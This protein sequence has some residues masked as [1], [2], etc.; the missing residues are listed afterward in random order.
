MPVTDADDN[1]YG[2]KSILDYVGL[3]T[4]LKRL[5]L[6]QQSPNFNRKITIGVVAIISVLL[7]YLFLTALSDDDEVAET[8]ATKK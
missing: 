2:R 6:M 5:S 1:K 7:L 3:R 8:V 4:F